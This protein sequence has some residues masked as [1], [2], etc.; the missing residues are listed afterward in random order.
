MTDGSAS[1]NRLHPMLTSTRL[2][3]GVGS[4]GRLE[5]LGSESFASHC[6]YKP[7]LCCKEIGVDSSFTDWERGAECVSKDKELCMPSV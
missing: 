3:A 7:P 2:V 6:L 1:S 5:D 4:Y